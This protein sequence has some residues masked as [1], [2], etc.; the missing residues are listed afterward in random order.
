MNDLPHPVHFA[1]DLGPGPFQSCLAQ[2]DGVR[3]HRTAGMDSLGIGPFRELNSLAF[4]ELGQIFV[5]FVFL[6][7]FH[8]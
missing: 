6:Y 7:V 2:V 1:F 3:Q 4:Q 5:K 8:K